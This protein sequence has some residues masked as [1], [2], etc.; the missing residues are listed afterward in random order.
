MFIIYDIETN[1]KIKNWNRRADTSDNWPRIVSIAWRFYG[2]D[3]R[4]IQNINLVVRPDGWTIPKSATDVHGFNDEKARIEGRD[5]LYV[6]QC[7]LLVHG[8]SKYQIG[9]NIAFDR[10]IIQCE[11]LRIFKKYH[12][13]GESKPYDMK[14][15]ESICTM[16]KTRKF[17]NLANKNGIK[18]KPPKLSELYQ[19]L[20]NKQPSGDLHDASYDVKITSECFFELLDRN[21]IEL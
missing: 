7:F 1:G 6:L 19:K 3:R 13:L 8:Q 2:M 9:H 12:Y 21:I 18:G 17:C 20:F 5:L 14:S 11:I 4:L 16:N 15:I 10:K